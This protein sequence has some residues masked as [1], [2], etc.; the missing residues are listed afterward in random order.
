MPSPPPLPI[1]QI[2]LATFA[3]KSIE[4]LQRHPFRSFLILVLVWMLT[5]VASV[6]VIVKWLAS[7]KPTK[8]AVALDKCPSCGRTAGGGK[9][10]SKD[11]DS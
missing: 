5:V 11:K 3:G 2:I 8:G 7:P 10:E 6:W 4:S 1:P 9:A